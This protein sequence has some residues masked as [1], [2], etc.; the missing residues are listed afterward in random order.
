[1]KINNKKNIRESDPQKE[2]EVKLYENPIPSR[3]LILEVM[4]DH[5]VPIKKNDLIQL[6][7]IQ[8]SEAIFLE[9]RLRAMARQGQILINRKDILCISEKLNLIPGRV[10]GHPDG[11]GFLIP[12]DKVVN[13]IFLSPREMSQV[14]NNDRVMVQ[15]TGQDRKGRLEGTIVEILERVNKIIVGRVVQGLSLIH[16]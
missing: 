9:K 6:L 10:M 5:G 11:F 2:R 7:D 8:E 16:I 15:V 4:T 12:D 13:D 14:L 1:M 3:E